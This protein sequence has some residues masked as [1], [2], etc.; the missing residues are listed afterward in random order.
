MTI[1]VE[2]L[3]E[4][5]KALDDANRRNNRDAVAAVARDIERHEDEMYREEA[6]K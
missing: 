6:R 3:R 5:R 1:T 2:K 4:W